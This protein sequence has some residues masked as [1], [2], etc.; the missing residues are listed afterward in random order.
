M[1]LWARSDVT[2]HSQFVHVAAEHGALPVGK[3]LDG[4]E[5][6]IDYSALPRITFT[7]PV[8][9]SAGPTEARALE[10][11]I[12]CECRA[13]DLESVPRASVSHN[14]RGAFMLVA[15]RGTGRVIGVHLLGAGGAI[16]AGVYATEARRTVADMAHGWDPYLT[17]GEAIHLA[18]LAFTRDP[19]RL[20]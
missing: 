16:L 17:I 20:S 5:R 14:T 19:S 18:A 6:R 11:G 15:E 1:R 10:Q 9:A 4:A 2:G 12:D 3:A 13:P 7:N 8:V